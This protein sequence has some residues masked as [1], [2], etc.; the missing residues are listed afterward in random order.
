MFSTNGRRKGSKEEASKKK[1][2]KTKLVCKD[3][4]FVEEEC[5]S[6]FGETAKCTS[7]Q[8]TNVRYEYA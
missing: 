8:S 1:T 4:G 3:C 2:F 6:V 7:C 5:S